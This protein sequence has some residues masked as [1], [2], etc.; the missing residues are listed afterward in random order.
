MSKSQSSRIWLLA[1]TVAI[2]LFETACGGGGGG[3][4]IDVGSGGTGISGTVVKGPVGNATVRAYALAGGRQGT[5]IGSATTDGNGNYAMTLGGYT[6]PVMLQASGG[7]YRDEATGFMH[8]MAPG[9]VMAA[10]I[11][12]V[13]S[14]TTA[15]GTQIT[16]ITS[17][18]QARAMQMAGGMTESNIAAANTAMGNYF[19]VS[20]ILHVHPMN[21]LV[22]GSGSAASPDAR[23][24]G[25][26]LAAMS[27]YA[28]SLNMANTSALVTSMMSDASDGMMDGRMGSGSISMTM[29]GMMGTSMMVPT[30]GTSGLA[31][32][33]MDFITSPANMSG[34]TAT[35][36]A[37]LVQRVSGSGGR[38]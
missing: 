2:A 36:I 5:Q 25:V 33:M 10:V 29:G 14:G 15:T 35:D 17:M 8:V 32:A 34:L 23:N 24:Y 9:D 31:T 19:S 11:A 37:P 1:A 3:G 4:S 28:K 26:T 6:G 12:S 38:I 22:T 7:S 16:P 27:Q 21:P 20:D 13:P 30:V 18:A